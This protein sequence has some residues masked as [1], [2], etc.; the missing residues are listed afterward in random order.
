MSRPSLFQQ[1]KTQPR[2]VLDK[3]YEGTSHCANVPMHSPWACKAVFQSL[4][5]VA[6][7]FVMKLLFVETNFSAKDFLLW[8]SSSSY[9]VCCGESF[10]ELLILSIITEENDGKRTEETKYRLNPSFQASLK[11]AIACP[12]EPWSECAN[13]GITQKKT[14]T[15]EELDRFS[16]ER[17]NEVLGFLVNLLPPSSQPTNILLVFVKRSGLM[18]DGVDA[19]GKRGLVITAKGYE[20]MLKDYLSQVWEFVMVAMKFSQSPEDALSLLFTLS[21]CTLGK[22][23]PMDALSKPQQQLVFEFSQVGIVY[24]PSITSPMFYPSRVAIN[25]IFGSSEALRMSPCGSNSSSGGVNAEGHGSSNGGTQIGSAGGVGNIPLQIIVETNNQVVAY[26]TSDIHLAMLQLFVE[27]SVRM[28][29]MAL[30][31]ITKE[32]VRQAF[33]MGIRAAQV[34]DFLVLHAHPMVAGKAHVVPENVTDELAL[35]EAES[36]RL[37]TEEAVVV[38]F[39]EFSDL[40]RKEF[41]DVVDALGQAGVLL[42]D[43]AEK[44]VVAVS[45]EGVQAVR[46]CMQQ[47]RRF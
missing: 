20:Y 25:M 16:T 31:R 3:L 6:K 45:P 30:G 8:S 21:Y 24:M 13:L 37:Q 10:N 23:Y 27:L 9:D 19:N 1:L 28:P 33:K 14:F 34:V 36:Q 44:M 47:L 42:W 29:N 32:K 17:W 12:I 43:S 39:R 40:S 22:G 38:D 26:L 2:I 18:V 46:A 5:S 11:K 4:S 35:W 15:P 41:T 7:C